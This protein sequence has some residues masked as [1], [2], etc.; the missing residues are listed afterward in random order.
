ML[1][2]MGF[3]EG[4]IATEQHSINFF[5]ECQSAELVSTIK[6]PTKL[7]QKSNRHIIPSLYVI[8]FQMLFSS[9]L[10]VI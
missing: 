9:I 10:M 4:K 2:D 6:I 5:T 3:P 8:P 1:D 7:V